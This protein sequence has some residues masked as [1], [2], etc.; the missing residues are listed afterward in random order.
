MPLPHLFFALF[1]FAVLLVVLLVDKK[2]IKNYV[3]LGIF[4]LAAAFVFET[5]TTALG[6]W[7]YHSEPKV[8]VISLYTWLL[9]IPY[10]SFC[11]FIGSRLAGHSVSSRISRGRV[12]QSG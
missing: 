11:Y 5:A 8:F 4:G 12:G 10:L 3:L 1:N 2:N 6:F 7:Y 9:Y